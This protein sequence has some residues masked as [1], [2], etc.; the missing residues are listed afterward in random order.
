MVN[1]FNIEMIVEMGV[2]KLISFL[3][4]E[5]GIDNEEQ[6]PRLKQILQEVAMNYLSKGQ[7][8][9]LNYRENEGSLATLLKDLDI[10][11]KNPVDFNYTISRNYITLHKSQE[12]IE[13][14]YLDESIRLSMIDK[15]KESIEN[16]KFGDSLCIK[17]KERIKYL[18]SLKESV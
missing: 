12:P 10:S 11:L 7:E 4:K 17:Y 15:L 14:I 3:I 13:Y 8:L 5:I 1:E 18:E 2:D 9:S 6:V 16:K